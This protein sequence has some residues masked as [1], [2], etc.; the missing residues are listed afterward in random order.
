MG[1]KMPRWTAGYYRSIRH[2]VITPIGDKHR[3]SVPCLLNGNLKLNVK[4]LD[5]SGIGII[6]G[7]HMRQRLIETRGDSGEILK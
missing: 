1:D 2:R 3:Y 4:W 7:E 6:E 5:G